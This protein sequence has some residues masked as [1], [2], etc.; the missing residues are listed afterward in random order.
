MAEECGYIKPPEE[1]AERF[2]E[3]LHERGRGHRRILY[4]LQK[5]GLPPVDKDPERELEKGR[6]QLDKLLMKSDDQSFQAKQKAMRSLANRGFEM[7]TIRQVMD[8]KF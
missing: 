4:E 8:E 1:L 2:A 5:K 6:Q 7:D 3:A